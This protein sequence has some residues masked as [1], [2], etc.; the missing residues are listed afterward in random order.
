MNARREIAIAASFVMLAGC[1]AAP[2]NTT[3]KPPEPASDERPYDFKQEGR[4]PAPASSTPVEADVEEIPLSSG[5]LD[6]SDAEAPPPDTTAAARPDSTA[7]GFRV[8]V[9]ASA[10]REVAQNAARVAEER[11][12]LPAYVDLEA[13]MYKVRMG[14]YLQRPAAE[15]ALGTLRSH[16]YP[17]AWIVPARVRVPRTR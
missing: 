7:D 10:D 15:A 6:V 4:V 11:L 1:A 8:Q 16:Y 13:G 14:D 5:G 2:R 9:F 12:G 17:D 3:S